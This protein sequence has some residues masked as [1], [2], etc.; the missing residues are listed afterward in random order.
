MI[1]F[2][3]EKDARGMNKEFETYID[4]VLLQSSEPI[5]LWPKSIT[6]SIFGLNTDETSVIS[7]PIRGF[8]AE[9]GLTITPHDSHSSAIANIYMI[10][11]DDISLVS[12]ELVYLLK[13]PSEDMG[14]YYTRMETN[15]RTGW[16][17]ETGWS[18]T[19]PVYLINIVQK[20]RYY[21]RLRYF[22]PTLWFR[23]L[24]P[25][26]SPTQRY[27]NS[28]FKQ[29]SISVAMVNDISESFSAYDKILLSII[30]SYPD[31]NRILPISKEYIRAQFNLRFR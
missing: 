1:C 25:A 30:C 18:D 6:Y 15:F 16:I 8:S 2:F 11:T 7:A 22:A 5:K 26:F 24:Y 9:I 4:A 20:E 28:I 13:K 31:K 17:T 29:P 10:F 19:S 21:H 14:A 3:F 23:S 12:R 27:D